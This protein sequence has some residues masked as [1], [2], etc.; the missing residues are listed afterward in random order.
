MPIRNLKE[1]R[2][3]PEQPSE[4]DWLLQPPPNEG[5]RIVVQLDGKTAQEQEVKDALH[6]LMTSLQATDELSLKT[7]MSCGEY[8][9]CNNYHYP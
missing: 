7:A 8:I 6:T 5:A 3:V 9:H 1:E 4:S 2:Q